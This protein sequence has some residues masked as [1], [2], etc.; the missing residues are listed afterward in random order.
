MLSFPRPVVPLIARRDDAAYMRAAGL[1]VVAGLRSMLPL[2]LLAAAVNPNGPLNGYAPSRG[3]SLS[4][5]VFGLTLTMDGKQGVEAVRIIAP[6]VAVP[7][8]YDEYD[9]FKSPVGD[10]KREVRAAGPEGKGRS[11][12]RGERIPPPSLHRRSG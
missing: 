11:V 12:A 6:D 1:G 3:D 10:F 9:V 4:A 2:G 7:V 5:R 8:H